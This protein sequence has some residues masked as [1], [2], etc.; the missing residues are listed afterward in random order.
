MEL[1]L[2]HVSKSV[3]VSNRDKTQQSAYRGHGC[4]LGNGN[5]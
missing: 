4:I 5:P 3:P 1:K 2:N